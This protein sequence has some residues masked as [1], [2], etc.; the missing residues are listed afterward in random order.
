MVPILY[1]H[2]K[3]KVINYIL[4]TRVKV[5]AHIGRTKNPSNIHDDNI[6]WIKVGGKL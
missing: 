3:Y 1:Y 4:V 5:A 6:V 2:Y